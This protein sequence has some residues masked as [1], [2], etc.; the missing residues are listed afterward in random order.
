[1]C[2]THF[3]YVVE[4]GVE[5]L[6]AVVKDLYNRCG[7]KWPLIILSNTRIRVLLENP[8]HRKLIE[9]WMEKDVFY[10]TP[11]GSNDDWY[12]H[13]DQLECIFSCFILFHLWLKFFILYTI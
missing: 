2:I 9:E 7:Q 3:S 10:A 5:Q 8:S 13:P 6:D 4:I 11:R 12:E 1:M